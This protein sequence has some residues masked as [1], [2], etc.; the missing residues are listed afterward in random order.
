MHLPPA[1]AV[2]RVLSN[3]SLVRFPSVV[4]ERSAYERVGGFRDDVGGADD[5]D[6]WIRLFSRYGVT[7]EIPEASAYTIHPGADTETMFDERTIGHLLELFD[8]ARGQGLIDLLD[9]ELAQA[10]Y[11]HQFILG[12]AYR[13]LLTGDRAGARSIMA[14]FDMPELADLG[15]SYRWAPVRVVFRMLLVLPVPVWSA[16]AALAGRFEQRTRSWL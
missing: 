16:T 11:F 2:R 6:M 13:R 3:S 1:V 9:L 8:S 12:G 4:V 14:L 10:D 7:L 5:L 15:F